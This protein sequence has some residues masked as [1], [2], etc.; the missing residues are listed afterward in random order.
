LNNRVLL[1]L[2]FDRIGRGENEGFGAGNGLIHAHPAYADSRGA[3]DYVVPYIKLLIAIRDKLV[4]AS[5][6]PGTTSYLIAIRDK[7][8]LGTTSYLIAIREKLV[9][10]SY[11]N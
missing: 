3:R 4:L 7:L 9:L 2:E 5:Y 11:I 6:I 1:V 10:G 8:V